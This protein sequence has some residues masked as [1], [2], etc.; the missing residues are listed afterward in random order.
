MRE[1]VACG[2]ELNG[3]EESRPLKQ[4]QLRC[5]VESGKKAV[6][7]LLL[8]KGADIN[9]ERADGLTALDIVLKVDPEASDE[10]RALRKAI[11]R[12]LVRNGA[13]AAQHK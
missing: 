6:A 4:T 7:E 11:A 13:T 8:A 5:A 10:D 3:P 2:T 12:M 9:T 1:H